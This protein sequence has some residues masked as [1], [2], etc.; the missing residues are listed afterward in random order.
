MNKQTGITF[1]A[2]GLVLW[3]IGP[4]LGLNVGYLGYLAVIAGLVI[5]ILDFVKKNKK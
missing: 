2:V 5:L 4:M 3:L 1:V